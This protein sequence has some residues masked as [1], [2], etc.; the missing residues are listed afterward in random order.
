M[1]VNQRYIINP[2]TKRS[3]YVKCGKCPACL[4]EKAIHRVRR[5]KNTETD[6][7]DC[8]MVSLTYARGCAPYIDRSEAYNFSHGRL[9]YLNVY[10]DSSFRRVRRDSSYEFNYRRTPGKVVLDKVPFEF[11]CNFDNIKDLKY[12]HGK[13]G[14]TYYPDLQRFM[15]RLR[16]NLKRVF[17]YDKLF[18][19]FCCS[20]YGTKSLRPHMHL[21]FFYPKGD[22]EVMRSAI[23][24]S[25]PFSNLQN[26][27]RSIEKCFRG[28]SYV[29][30][31][32]NNG[33]RFPD[34]LK[35]YFKPKHSYSKGFGLG[36]RYFS[37]RSI[38]HAFERGSLSYGVAKITGG[39][40]S[41]SRLPI[42]AYVIHRYFPKFKG[43]T[44]INPA[45]LF[46]NM[47]RLGNGEIEQ[48]NSS[49]APLY[50]SDEEFHKINTR[51]HNAMSRCWSECPDL[52]SSTFD[53]YYRLHIRIWDMYKSNLLRFQM[54]N[55]DLYLFEKYDNLQEVSAMV[56]DG[57]MPLPRGFTRSMLRDNPDPN[58][59]PHNVAKHI[60]LVDDF[61][62]NIKHRA[63]VNVISSS[64]SEE[65]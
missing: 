47:R 31:Y 8:M 32:V 61:H 16:L 34:F 22:F 53:E 50:Y 39:S 41:F 33:S 45:T 63:V 9:P 58:K 18:K 20:E 57:I 28:A 65:W 12:E 51:L 40:L 60:K 2:Y 27:P 4:Q 43:Y 49:V 56:V 37:L 64:L 26:F 48:L 5:I 55:D 23:V 13:I 6:A 36:N 54:E 7:L 44:R 17:K 59:Y 46:D 29:A 38:L 21:L 14:V 30:S 52:M 1:C 15:A 19:A 10:R 42:P 62:M 25:W 3:L 11:Q 24:K 35:S